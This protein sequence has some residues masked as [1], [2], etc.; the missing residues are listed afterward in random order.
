[1]DTISLSIKELEMAKFNS[2]AD[3]VNH[4]AYVLV[5][6]PN[7]VQDRAMT[8]E[9][10]RRH[11]ALFEMFKEEVRN[12][13]SGIPNV[14]TLVERMQRANAEGSTL[15]PMSMGYWWMKMPEDGPNDPPSVVWFW[16]TEE[17]HEIPDEDGE[18]SGNGQ[19]AG[20]RSSYGYLDWTTT[21]RAL[22]LR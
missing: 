3:L 17:F 8:P 16:T 5:S 21:L 10:W 14:I 15:V 19:W 4:V 7:I 12:S 18:Y 20:V 9:D 2:F 13:F 6:D 1:M 22:H 11:D